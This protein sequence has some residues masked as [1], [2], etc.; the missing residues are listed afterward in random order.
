MSQDSR[1][2][3]S[4]IEEVKMGMRIKSIYIILA[5]SSLVVKVGSGGRVSG[6]IG[7]S[8]RGFQRLSIKS[9]ALK[10]NITTQRAVTAG[11][12][13]LNLPEDVGQFITSRKSTTSSA[14][15]RP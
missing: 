10:R 11:C 7:A 13:D 8:K 15:G 14:L 5:F 6:I 4:Y 1:P 2:R 12:C 9:S 3:K